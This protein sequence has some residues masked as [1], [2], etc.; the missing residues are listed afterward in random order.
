MRGVFDFEAQPPLQVKGQDEP[1]RTWLVLRAKPRAFRV[2]TRGIEGAETPLVG[3]DAE[4]AQLVAAFEATVR[5]RRL[6]ALTLLA[7][8][9][10]G[11]SRLIQE[12]QHRLET[13]PQPCWLL[14]GRALPSGTL[15][16]YGLLRDVLAWR[17]QIADSDSAEVA[18]RSLVEGLAPYL[19]EHGETA[20]R[21]ARPA[22]R[23]ST[24]R[25]ARGSPACSRNAVSCATAPSPLSTAM[26]WPCAT[27]RFAGGRDAARRPALGR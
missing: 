4:L 21:A 25:P 19:G 5:T 2:A 14:L 23:A 9:G 7:E 24:S 10:L 26:C 3:R 6:Q 17:L 18:R 20:G 12:L 1:L 11:K 27:R 15:Q 22:R 8:A 16:P 13:H